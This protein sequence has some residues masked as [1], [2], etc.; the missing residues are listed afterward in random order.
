MSWT[1]YVLDGWRELVVRYISHGGVMP[2]TTVGAETEYEQP[3][4]SSGVILPCSSNNASAVSGCLYL[5]TN[6]EAACIKLATQLSGALH[7]LDIDCLGTGPG[8]SA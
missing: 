3:R 2:I 8:L 7:P 5:F 1:A 4:M 6:L